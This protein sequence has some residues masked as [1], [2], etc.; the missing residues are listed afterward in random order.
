MEALLTRVADYLWRQSWQIALLIAVVALTTWALRNRSAHVRYL[1]WLLVLAKCLA[2]PVVEVPLPVL[3]DQAPVVA[4][5][6]AP[7]VPFEGEV[8]ERPVPERPRPTSSSPTPVPRPPT[9]VSPAREPLQLTTAQWLAVGWLAGAA[10]FLCVA[11]AKAA[12]TILW[13]RH[14]RRS[15][16]RTAGD[17][18]DKTFRSLRVRRPPRVWLMAD[19]GQPFVWGLV[20]GDIYLPESFVQTGNDEHRR[21][22]LAH[23]ISH[24][25]RFD[26]A[27]NLLQIFVQTIFWFHPLLWWAN[28]RIRR[29]REKCCDEMA[30]A[31]LNAKPR[32][33][34]TAIVNTLIQAQES[35]RPVPSLA[36]AGPVRNLEERISAMLRPGKTFQRRPSL[37]AATITVFVALVTI[38]TALVLTVRAASQPPSDAPSADRV[39][40]NPAN[41]G[42]PVNS[43]TDELNPSISADEL[44]LYF[45]SYRSAGLGQADLWVAMRR[46]KGE[47]WGDPVNLGPT[48][49]GPAGDDTPCI[50][51]DGLALYFSSDRPGGSGGLDLWMT[52]RKTKSSAWGEPVNLG[53]AV[54]SAA[55]EHA[56]SISSDG[57]E[58][59]FS[60]HILYHGSARP[61]GSGG[62]DLWV[63]IR[64][65]TDDPWGEPVNLGPTVNSPVG[66]AGPSISGD[67]LSLYFVS[68][69]PGG[70]GMGDLW[71]TTR[72]SK[73]DPW[74]APVNL[75][76]AVSSGWWDLDPDISRGGSALYF[77]SRRSVGL[78]GFDIWQATLGPRVEETAESR[79]RSKLT[80]SLDEAVKAGDIEQVRSLLSRG[81]DANARDEEGRTPLHWA[82]RY[83]RREVAQVLIAGGANV[84]ETDAARQTPLHLAGNFGTK[85]VPE[86][87]LAKGADINAR[88]IA[89]NTPLH[90]VTGCA[91][92]SPDLLELLIAK[93][94]DVKARNAAGQTP[95]HRVAM[96]R[97]QNNYRLELTA[98]VLLAHGA[99]IDARDKSGNTPL[100]F[101]VENGYRRLIDLLLA[102]GADVK[103]RAADGATPLHR[104][105]TNGRSD[106]VELLIERGANVNAETV[107]GETPAQLA[108]LRKQK[109]MVRLL[110]SKGAEVST[111]PL[112]AYV[113]DLA[114]VKGLVEKGASVNAQ[115]QYWPTPLHT[116]AAGGQRE[117]AEFLISNGA[118]VNV[119]AVAQDGETP[120]HCAARGGSTEV[121]ELLL[122]K[123]AKVNAATRNGTALHEA[124]WCGDVN[125][126]RLLLAHGADV[127]AKTSYRMTPLQWAARTGREDMVLLLL[128]HG[129]DINADDGN[130]QT[131][132]LCAASSGR[133]EVV[134]LLL[135]KGAVTSKDD[136]RLLYVACCRGHKDLAEL[137]VKKGANVNSKP[138]GN[139]LTLEVLWSSLTSER[140]LGV[141]KLLL[142]HGADPNAKDD[143]DW[144]LLH[145]ACGDV[146][147]AKLLLD[148]GANPNAVESER[149]FTC[150]HI[151]ADKGNKA[152]VQLLLSR[153]AKVNVRDDYGRTPLSYAEDL[154]DNDMEGRPRSTPLTAEARA[155]K[156]EVAELL[157][158]HGATE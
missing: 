130:G 128:D 150:L 51:A 142:D 58:L 143:S 50:S 2:P 132:L 74:G 103:A 139:A 27:V 7:A 140:K 124:A 148:K 56:P 34:S 79:A 134:K 96:I 5:P 119:A 13:L 39:F 111:L 54:N 112:A 152:V 138:W 115:D 52:R 32:D 37:V 92:V 45:S 158:R 3:P 10:L 14:E 98:E 65:T 123:G 141:L 57:L 156:K 8:T 12:R 33:Y 71:V 38:P 133:A 35:T 76:P 69:R 46:A 42:P 105:V 145:Y 102:K 48:V 94:A 43:S 120:L 91:D 82:A 49:N 113:G 6:T 15:L 106:M 44:E 41:L 72:K 89:G 62:A 137:L 99:E 95:L 154:G 125:M 47:P 67:G 53:P 19:I 29:E 31:H 131:P 122:S 68:D 4:A 75:G 70:F 88:D 144:S 129:A 87:L 155:A 23:E 147:L 97:R 25:L 90:I 153:G 40:G 78:G 151:M 28:Q 110:L 11:L 22:I 21:D 63:T 108:V 149:G 126:V 121:A 116:A 24:V 80:A 1:L 83:G 66:D 93:G 18:L 60:G 84:D 36:V 114:Q 55:D 127:S 86:L 135:D 61:G 16:P 81:A 30:I 20:R 73:S 146:D 117:V 118:S 59:Y 101:A 104:A 136:N 107:R 77:S 109:D 100:H 157:R 9:P 26:A 64:K 17:S 85:F